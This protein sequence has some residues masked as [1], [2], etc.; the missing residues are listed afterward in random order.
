MKSL[1][2]RVQVTESLRLHK[3]MHE[4]RYA[5]KIQQSA[6]GEKEHRPSDARRSAVRQRFLPESRTDAL[7]LVVV[8]NVRG[9]QGSVQRP[10]APAL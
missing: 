7:R 3:L 10:E 5:P 8:L 2:T 6:N 4:S 9:L 1:S